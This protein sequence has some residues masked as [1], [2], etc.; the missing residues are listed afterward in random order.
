MNRTARMMLFANQSNRSRHSGR[1]Y[2]YAQND[3]RYRPEEHVME[4]HK[5]YPEHIGETKARE[6][7]MH[8]KNSD[9][10]QG[11]HFSPETAEPLRAAHCPDCDKWDF[12][13]AIN[14]IYSDYGAVIKKFGVDK[15]EVYA[16]LAK[17]FLEDED[18]GKHKLR[19]YIDAMQ[20]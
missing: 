9:G 16:C 6:W 19:K 11:T 2:D 18:A 12:F 15:P 8:M 4:A 17:A 13:A 3:G 10:T 7:V 20:G 5:A 14:M 1:E